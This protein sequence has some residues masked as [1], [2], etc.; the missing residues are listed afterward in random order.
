M[1]ACA[2]GWYRGCARAAIDLCGCCAARPTRAAVGA[3][4]LQG[5]DA[6][7]AAAP[8]TPRRCA[9]SRRLLAAE[10]SEFVPTPPV[11][12]FAPGC[13][14]NAPKPSRK[15]EEAQALENLQRR[16]E[17]SRLQKVRPAQPL[18]KHST[19]LD[20]RAPL[21]HKVNKKFRSRSTNEITNVYHPEFIFSLKQWNIETLCQFVRQ[22]G[23]TAVTEYFN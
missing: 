6:L 1:C 2:E 12:S 4:E 9:A 19:M 22:K 7:E 18:V 10:R 15:R 3:M 13:G 14:A 16:V 5:A 8:A 23:S 20:N 11:V 17:A 21:V